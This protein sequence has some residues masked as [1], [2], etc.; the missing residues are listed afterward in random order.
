MVVR[1]VQPFQRRHEFFVA[2]FQQRTNV[3]M[4]YIQGFQTEHV[5]KGAREFGQF[6][7]RQVQRL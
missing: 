7:V 3:V 6:I 5:S 1:Q 2:V 4:R